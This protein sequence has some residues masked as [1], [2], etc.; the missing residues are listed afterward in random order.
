MKSKKTILVTGS[1]GQ[2]A[3][4]I[5]QI[6]QENKVSN[7]FNFIFQPKKNLDISKKYQVDDIFLSNS[8]DLVI[9]CAAYTRVDLAEKEQDL[10]FDI[11][12]SGVKNIVDSATDQNIGLIQISTDYVFD[13]ETDEGIFENTPT[14]P[15]NTYG[16]SK[17]AAEKIIIDSKLN[18]AIIRTSWLYSSFGHNFFKSII[19]KIN[20]KEDL[21]IVDDQIGSPTYAKDLAKFILHTLEKMIN[22]KEFREIFHYSNEGSASWYDF[23]VEISKLHSTDNNVQISK[24]KSKNLNLAAK[25][26]KYSVLDTTKAKRFL[27]TDL[28]NWKSSLHKCYKFYMD[29]QK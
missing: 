25:R 16:M 13:G 19:T 12:K 3:K 18:Y 23:A 17:A 1:N 14:N 27:M 10:C 2:L 26:P 20:Q 11:N 22:S 6:V 8:I 9:N 7:T 5:Q 24:V 4:E 15:L 21:K 29:T 28:E